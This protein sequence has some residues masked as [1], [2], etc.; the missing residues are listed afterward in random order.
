MVALTSRTD[1]LKKRDFPLASVDGQKRLLVGAAISTREQDRERAEALVKAGVDVIVIDSSQGDS[2][3]QLDC[4]AHLKKSYPSLQVVG[5]NVVTQRQALS[6]IRAGADG[7]RIGMGSGSLLTKV[8]TLH[9]IIW[10]GMGSGS[11][12]ITQEVLACGRPQGTAVYRV[13]QLARTFGVPVIADGGVSSIGHIV[14]A[15]S[16]GANV[17]MMGSMLAGTQEA[18]GN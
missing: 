3:Y 15:V 16:L 10:I 11:I 6:L 14:K 18:P 5:G 1:L 2:H 8:I 17:V 9:I 7:L 12:C 4:I 13:A